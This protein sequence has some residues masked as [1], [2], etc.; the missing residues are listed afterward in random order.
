[1]PRTR[2]R[3]TLAMLLVLLAGVLSGILVGEIIVT[4]LHSR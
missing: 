1:V 2:T 4:A 3:R